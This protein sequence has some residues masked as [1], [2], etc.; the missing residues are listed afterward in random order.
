M[1]YTTGHAELDITEQLSMCM[2]AHT[3][4]HTH[5]HTEVIYK[6]VPCMITYICSKLGTT[7]TSLAERIFSFWKSYSGDIMQ[8]R[9]EWS[10]IHYH[11]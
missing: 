3:Q 5:T 8:Q 1:A 2:R 4:T 7:L 9:N 10:S 6:N 11:I